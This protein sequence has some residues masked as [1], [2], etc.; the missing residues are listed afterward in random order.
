[1]SSE[2]FTDQKADNLS[3]SSHKKF[4]KRQTFNKLTLN[5][6]LMFI[7][8]TSL[9]K[10]TNF[11]QSL[12]WSQRFDSFSKMVMSLNRRQYINNTCSKY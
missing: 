3:Y 9:Q 5:N 2:L 7:F 6:L 11:R 1:M 12:Q 4:I 10:E 8:Y